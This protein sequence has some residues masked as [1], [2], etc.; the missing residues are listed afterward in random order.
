MK[1]NQLVHI[2]MLNLTGYINSYITYTVNSQLSIELTVMD[3][4][5]KQIIS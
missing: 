5:D 1:Q 2:L 3:T 4:A